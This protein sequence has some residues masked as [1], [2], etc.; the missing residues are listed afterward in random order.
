M[1]LPEINRFEIPLSEQISQNEY[2]QKVSAIISQVYDTPKAYL[3]SFGCQGN[4]AEGE[5]IRSILINAGYLITNNPDESDLVVLN[6]C[7]IREHAQ[8]RAFGNI[9]ALKKLKSANKNFKIALCGCMVQQKSVL[10]KIKSSYPFVDIVFGTHVIHKL[11][12]FLYRNFS[13]GKKVYDITDSEGVINEHISATR[14]NSFKAFVP[15]MYGCNNFCTYCIV[16]YVKGRERSRSPKAI[17]DEVNQLIKSG[18]KE[19]TLI[20]QNVNSYGKNPDYG[21]DFSRL[22]K[23]IDSIEGDF[24]IRFMTSHPKDCTKKLLDTMA[25]SKKIAH[26]L[27][28]PVQSGNNNT[29]ERMNRRYTVEK[30]IDLV[31]YAY[32]VMPDLSLTSDIIVGFPGETEDEFEDTVSLVKKVHFTSIYEFIFSPREGTAAAMMEDPVSREIKGK[33]FKK[34]QDAQEEVAK[35]RT[36]QML[37]KTYRVLCERKNSNGNIEGRTNGNII[38]EFPGSEEFIGQFVNV[39]IT[40]ALTWVLKGETV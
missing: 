4:V 34:L 21:Y 12:E 39:K 17:L 1:V 30:Y 7:A 37:G 25:D 38:V 26:H 27:H 11:P 3:H 20:G 15:I 10:D 2:L 8:D 22:L 40:Q 24:V 33:W 16:P 29:L 19:I 14:D 32:K 13:T 35:T 6:T 31:D 9:G 5:K 18:Y 28:L 23:E 36:T